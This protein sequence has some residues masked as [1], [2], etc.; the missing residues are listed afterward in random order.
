MHLSRISLN[1]KIFLKCVLWTNRDS[2]LIDK[3]KNS[4]FFFFNLFFHLYL[5]FISFF[6][7]PA[8]SG[9][10]IWKAGREVALRAVYTTDCWLSIENWDIQWM[11]LLLL[12]P[13]INEFIRHLMKALISRL[14]GVILGDWQFWVPPYGLPSRLTPLLLSLD[15][16]QI[17]LRLKV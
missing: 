11:W 15:L 4:S 14:S 8:Y 17:I 6:S 12:N 2:K 1:A 9:T 13:C 7:F 16:I 3:N 5:I 10:S